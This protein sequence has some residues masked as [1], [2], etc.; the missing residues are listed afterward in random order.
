MMVCLANPLLTMEARAP[1]PAHPLG[2]QSSKRIGPHPSAEFLTKD[3]TFSAE[4][5]FFRLDLRPVRR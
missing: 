1:I 3:R 4:T 5:N 2:Q